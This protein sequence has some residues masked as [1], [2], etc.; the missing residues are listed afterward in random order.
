VPRRLLF[1]PDYT[2]D[3]IWGADE[4]GMVN[5][6]DL[7]LSADIRA[8]ARDWTRRWERLAHAEQAS[9]ALADGTSTQPA[10]P[11]AQETWAAL[12]RDG[13]V[14]WQDLQAELGHSHQL[15][16]LTDDDQ[17]EWSP[18]S[19]PEPRPYPRLS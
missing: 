16:W 10:E 14:V 19:P 6:D 17:V 15:G 9:D 18:G 1:F 12:E 7:P 2:A 5:L 8:R 13:R 3:P 11:V 4:A